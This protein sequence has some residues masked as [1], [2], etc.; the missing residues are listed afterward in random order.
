MLQY[1]RFDDPMFVK[2]L[3]EVRRKWG[4]ILLVTDNASSTN[5][6]KCNGT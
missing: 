3:G 5:T 1:E 2:Y 6:G 4:K